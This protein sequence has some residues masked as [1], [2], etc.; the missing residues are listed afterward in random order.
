MQ[1]ADAQA[2][3]VGTLFGSE[4]IHGG[5]GAEPGEQPATVGDGAKAEEIL[6]ARSGRSRPRPR[7]SR[8]RPYRTL[9]L[10]LGAKPHL[11][12]SAVSPG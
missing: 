8:S 2:S 12:L 4:P 7:G 1:D 3:P 9:D 6:L 10:K 11:E 5:V